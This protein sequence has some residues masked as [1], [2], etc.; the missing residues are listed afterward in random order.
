[1][2]AT[3]EKRDDSIY[4]RRDEARVRH[5]NRRRGPTSRSE[6]SVDEQAFDGGVSAICTLLAGGE[7]T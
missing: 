5:D 6:V 3:P 4:D 7:G 2:S 1:M